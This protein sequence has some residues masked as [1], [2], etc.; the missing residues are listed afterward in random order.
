M[1]KTLWT[2]KEVIRMRFQI[3]S[4]KLSVKCHSF[5]YNDNNNDNRSNPQIQMPV[6]AI[7][8]YSPNKYRTTKIPLTPELNTLSNQRSLYSGTKMEFPLRALPTHYINIHN[9]TNK[10][11]P[12]G[13]MHVTVK[14]RKV[15]VLILSIAVD[16]ILSS[17]TSCPSKCS[18]ELNPNP[19]S[20]CTHTINL[21][22]L[23]VI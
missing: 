4:L 16:W 9:S 7:I 21:F 15:T 6:R 17:C 18:L 13:I 22:Q 23:D 11:K 5:P 10:T 12:K 19:T 1:K 2:L 14:Y 3:S 20:I 8:V